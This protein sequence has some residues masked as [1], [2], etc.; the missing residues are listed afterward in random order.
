MS[1]LGLSLQDL[2]ATGA[3]SFDL[4]GGTSF[5]G[6]T[7]SL[8]KRP[9]RINDL[10]AEQQAR[11]K[12]GA[13]SGGALAYVF[14]VLGVFVLG[15]AVVTAMKK[16]AAPPPGV[17]LGAFG[18]PPPA[19][20]PAP[21][22]AATASPPRPAT[23]PVTPKPA[24]AAPAPRP[25]T[26]AAPSGP[27]PTHALT[28]TPQGPSGLATASAADLAEQARLDAS[29]SA[30]LDKTFQAADQGAGQANVPQMTPGTVVAPGVT[31]GAAPSGN[32]AD[33]NTYVTSETAAPTASGGVF[34]RHRRHLRRQR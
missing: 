19:A 8:S 22:P 32:Q 23:A 15:T 26:P 5:R 24:Y 18:P 21:A 3:K 11:P 7:I 16:P 28:S 29:Q 14:G 2:Q 17:T 6:P 33:P 1:R 34:R 13:P 10:L 12:D 25:Y 20:K 4:G 27:M 31:V 9:G 30:Y